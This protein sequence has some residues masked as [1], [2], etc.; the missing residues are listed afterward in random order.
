MLVEER[1]S[2]GSELMEHQHTAE[3]TG[4]GSRVFG[5]S[6]TLLGGDEAIP[7]VKKLQCLPDLLVE[8]GLA[9]NGSR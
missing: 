8:E 9:K 5:I 7:T 1:A 4:F 6:S 2:F 3:A